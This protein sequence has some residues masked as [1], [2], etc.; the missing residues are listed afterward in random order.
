MGEEYINLADYGGLL[1]AL[2]PDHRIH[3]IRLPSLDYS[4]PPTSLRDWSISS[5]YKY[6]VPFDGTLMGSL[7]ST[8]YGLCPQSGALCTSDALMMQISFY[9]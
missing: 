1:P 2:A 7:L 3:T 6:S 8:A 5:V 9:M 4:S